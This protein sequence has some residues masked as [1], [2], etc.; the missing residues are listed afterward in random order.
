MIEQWQ[1]VYKHSKLPGPLKC[2]YSKVWVPHD[3]PE[4]SHGV[5]CQG[6]SL[7]TAQKPWGR[8]GRALDKRRSRGDPGGGGLVDSRGAAGAGRTAAL[9]VLLRA[10][11]PGAAAVGLGPPRPT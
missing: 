11:P 10:L 7:L 3:F 1:V 5:K 6:P 8:G 4:N 2:E 9:S